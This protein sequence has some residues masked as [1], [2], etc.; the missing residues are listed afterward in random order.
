MKLSIVVATYN[1]E[2]TLL[3]TL[4]SIVPHLGNDVELIVVDGGSTDKTCEIVRGV[5]SV[6]FFISE[7]DR[8]IYDAWNKAIKYCKG[9]YIAFVGSDDILLSNYKSVYFAIIDG[10]DEYDYVSSRVML[11]DKKRRLIGEEF[12]WCKFRRR[13]NVAHVGSLHNRRLYY[14]YGLYNIRYKI[15][16]DYDFLLRC[17]KGLRCA[18]SDTATVLMGVDGVSN[19][20]YIH[21]LKEACIAKIKTGAVGSGIAIFDLV[22]GIVKIS[23]RNAIIRFSGWCKF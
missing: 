22:L 19:S 15:V 9:D 17:G 3:A 6:A 5:P 11:D 7:K 12:N 4:N 8:G 1:S 14:K 2:K 18:Y 20:R 16:G 13:M 21:A 10:D 23:A